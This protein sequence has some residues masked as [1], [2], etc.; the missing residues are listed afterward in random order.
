MGFTNLNETVTPVQNFKMLMKD[1]GELVPMGELAV[2]E[3]L[4]KAGINARLIKRTNV[5]LYEVQ[6]YI[7]FS[8][9]I[10]DRE[11]KK[12]QESLDFIKSSG[13]YE[14]ILRKYLIE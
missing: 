8:K 10:S 13:E 5:K 9:D 4:K 6:L 3:T 14:K 2:P 1:R 11:I 7:A 12:W